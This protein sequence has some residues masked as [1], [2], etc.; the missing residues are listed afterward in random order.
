M[1]I[2]KAQRDKQRWISGIFTLRQSADDYFAL[3]PDEVRHRHS[4]IE[5]EGLTYPFYIIEDTEGFRFLSESEAYDV[6][7]HPSN[8][9]KK[10]EGDSTYAIL[11]RIEKDWVPKKPGWDYMGLLPHEHVTD[12]TLDLI[13]REGVAAIWPRLS[14]IITESTLAAMSKRL[15]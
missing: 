10:H 11:F 3:I 15:K 2:I 12:A 9:L 8:P 4:I 14:S 6:F 5:V 13:K 1:F 7:V